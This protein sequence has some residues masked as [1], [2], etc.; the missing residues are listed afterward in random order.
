[1]RS[2]L[3]GCGVLA[4]L[5]AGVAS[6]HHGSSEYDLNVVVRY[7]G[8]IVE[9]QW[10]N[11]HTLTRLATRTA[12][13]EPITLE[14]EGG[15]PSILRTSG[16]T[17]NSIVQG[18]HVT[19]VVSPSRRFPNQ[20]AYGLEIIKADGT[21][22]PLDWSRRQTAQ[23][24]QLAQTVPDIFRTWLPPRDLFDQMLHWAWSSQLTEKG[25]G[26]RARYSP[27]MHR[28]AECVPM[29]APMLMTYPVAQGLTQF[30]D[31]I[32]IRSDWLGAE[33]TVY[34]DG[35]DHPPLN[36]RFLQGHSTGRWEDKVLIVDTRNFADEVWATMP[37][38]EGKH[39]IERFAL[40][41]DGK[42]MNYSFVLEDPEY[43]VRPVSGG[44]QMS[45]RP[46]L[47]FGGVECDLELAKRFFRELQ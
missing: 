35:R 22:V 12:S 30:N 34:M 25:R 29:S 47:K 39:L 37:S 19:A 16:A 11:P 26:I 43:L 42:S 31:R 32:A 38:G 17:A 18:E 3:I 23:T 2:A 44:G 27:M 28:H 7:E 15:S 24:E 45:Y 40:S 6:S 13:G 8:V 14:I 21:V 1:M 10:R 4:A 41:P 36:E 5:Y 9:H 20:T 33:R 46:D